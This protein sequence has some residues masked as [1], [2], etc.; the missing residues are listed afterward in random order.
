LPS[1]QGSWVRFP[2]DATSFGKFGDIL[3]CVEQTTFNLTQTH[4]Y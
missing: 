1:K 3:Y 4:T 2:L